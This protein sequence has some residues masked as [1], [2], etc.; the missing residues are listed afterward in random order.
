MTVK[1]TYEELEKRVAELEALKTE[2]KQAEHGILKARNYA[3]KIV[4]TV[5][6]PLIVLDVHL[7]VVSANQSFFKTFSVE[8]EKTVGKLIYEIGNHQWNVPRLRELLEKL[9]PENTSF[10][11]F[12]VEHDFETIGH[13]IMLLN[14]RRLDT[15]RHG[16]NKI[17]L[18]IEDITERRQAEKTLSESQ[19]LIRALNEDI[20]NMLM[21]VSHDLRSPLVSAE[22]T[23]KL[24]I[25]GIY[26]KMDGSVKNTVSDL[27]GRIEKLRGVAEDCLGKASVVAGEVN[28]ERKVLDLRED[29]IDP[30]LN[31]LLQDMEE[32]NIVIDNRLGA[33][34]AKKFPIEADK[35]WLKIVFRNLFSNAIKYGGK[36]CVIAFGCEDSE[37]YYKLNVYNSGEPISEDFRDRLFTKFYRTGER[38]EVGSEGMGLGLYLTKQIVRKHGGDI[39]YEP[40]EWGSNFVLTL[41]RDIP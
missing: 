32:Q 8:P 15:N 36:G 4:E 33:V 27:Y 13:K 12:Q 21:V 14:A 22:A 3:E 30:V 17:L 35:I 10:D 1:P 6:E 40:R 25:R 29:I 7:N 11:D 26:G 31:E 34:P 20:L 37:A 23:L 2:L 18:A 41:P 39:W 38:N 5:R 19:N 28:F 16:A 24:L 9:I